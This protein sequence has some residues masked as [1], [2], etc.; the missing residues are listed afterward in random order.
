MWRH[1]AFQIVHINASVDNK[2]QT[3]FFWQTKKIQS[4]LREIK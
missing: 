2:K 3:V 1:F 4:I